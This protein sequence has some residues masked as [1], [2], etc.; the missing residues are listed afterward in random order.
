M[1]HYIIEEAIPES[2]DTEFFFEDDGYSDKSGDYNNTLFLVTHEL[3]HGYSSGI[4]SDEFKRITEQIKTLMDLFE[5]VENKC[6]SYYITYKDAITDAGLKYNPTMC[7]KLKQWMDNYGWHSINTESIAEYMSIITS[8]PW[9]VK[10]I[11]GYCQGD[12]VDV[13]YCKDNYDEN[14]IETIGEIYLGCYKEFSVTEYSDETELDT[15]YGYYVADNEI[16]HD[17][18]YKRIVCEQACINPEATKLRL[19]DYSHPVSIIRNYNYKT[20]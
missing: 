2:S 20:I 9:D 8:K 5:D 14:S 17:E 13:I 11:R 15:V 19:I 4:N 16:R 3:Y 12:F 7:H 1:K 6:N 18:D 10:T